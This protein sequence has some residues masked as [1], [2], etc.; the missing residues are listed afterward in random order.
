MKTKPHKI[1]ANFNKKIFNNLKIPYEIKYDLIYCQVFLRHYIKVHQ[2]WINHIQNSP[3]DTYAKECLKDLEN[4]I[5]E[6]GEEQKKL[7]EILREF[8]INHY[9]KLDD[10]KHRYDLIK[11]YG[12]AVVTKELYNTYVYVTLTQLNKS[13]LFEPINVKQRKTSAELLSKFKLK[14]CE[15]VVETKRK[16][17]PP[18]VLIPLESSVS[19]PTESRSAASTPPPVANTLGVAKTYEN[20]KQ[21][22]LL[23]PISERLSSSN[24]SVDE[25]ISQSTK[26]VVLEPNNSVSPPKPAVENALIKSS[27]LNLFNALK[28]AKTRLATTTITP[29]VKSPPSSNNSSPISSGKSSPIPIVRSPEPQTDS[30]NNDIIE[31]EDVYEEELDQEQFLR[32][33]GLYTLEKSIQITSKRRERRRRNV[34]STEKLDYHYGRFDFYEP[35]PQPLRRKKPILYSPPATRALKRR[36][37]SDECESGLRPPKISTSSSASTSNGIEKTNGCNTCYIRN[38]EKL[39]TCEKCSQNFHLKCHKNVFST[40]SLR[41]RENMCPCCFR[42]QQKL[43]TAMN[44]HIRG[45]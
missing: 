32:L 30:Q 4:D 7:S 6:L 1:E 39:N 27:R 5:R 8:V 31:Y 43:N 22:S 45:K 34:Q 26:S 42:Q 10:G 19:T 44:T 14:T 18:E 24:T 36:K 12:D 23:K 33:F 21:I 41:A 29:P 9:K 28:K 3:N 13:T 40:Q 17:K 20:T 16:T 11:E 37:G 25:S 2:L 15:V 35:K 38:G